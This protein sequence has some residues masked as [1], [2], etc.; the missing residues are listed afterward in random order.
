M[1]S[2]G[3]FARLAGVS[4][5]MLRHYDQLGLLRPQRVDPFSG[6][7]SYTAAQLDRANRLVALKDLGFTLEQVGAMLDDGMPGAS[8]A[9]LLRTRRGELAAQIDAD[10][11]RLREVETRL[12]S[13]EKEHPMSAF[14][15]TALPEL[16]LVQLAVK[17]SE[18]AQIEEEISG[19]FDRVNTLID[20]AAATRVGPGVAVYTDVED[21]MIAAA[22]EQIGDAPVPDGLEAATVAAHPRALTVRL[23]ADDLAGIQAA[24]QGLV[25]EIE[26][27][28]LRFDGA[29]REIYEQTPFDGP[30]ARWIVD[31]QQPVA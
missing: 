26:R 1:L 7:R 30:G 18:M 19:M 3:E 21:G 22:A 12:R 10:R 8:L 29:A 2:I 6:Y 11:Q 14:I 28:G 31:L 20:E 5:R 27:R 25:A 17:V 23:E 16:H 9:E 13:I 4:V 15:E 24:W